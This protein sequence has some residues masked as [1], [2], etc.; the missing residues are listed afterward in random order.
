[1]QLS[2]FLLAVALLASA[3]YV[4]IYA[5]GLAAAPVRSDGFGYFVYL[6]AAVVDRDLTLETTARECCGGTFPD[7]AAIIRWPGTNRLVGAHP[8]GV[9]MLL[10]PLYVVAHLLTLWSNLPPTGWSFYYQHA[11]GLG[12]VA[13]LVAGLA[14]LGRTLAR[15][16]APSSVLWTLAVVTFGTNLFHYGTFD[17]VYSHVF[18]FLLV[19][20][21]IHQV[22]LWF[23]A[24]TRARA[25]GI[26][27]I[28]SLVVLVRHPNAVALALIPAYGLWT[29]RSLRQQAALLWSRRASLALMAAAAF[30]VAVP[31]M[32]MYYRA[33]GR[34]L[35]SS[36]GAMW[37]HFA[38]PQLYGVL[39]SVQKGVFFWAPLLLLGVGG[40]FL[41]GPATP[42]V[43]P[44]AIVVPVTVYLIASWW[45][46]QYGG[47]FGHRGFTDLAGLFALGIAAV[48]E[49]ARRHRK[50]ALALRAAAVVLMAL[51]VA[52]MLQ[53][54]VGA[55]P[56][57][58]LTWP[59][60]RDGFL[61]F[62]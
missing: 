6:P 44:I 50:A 14:V 29:E 16:V 5:A 54:W 38:D 36:Y 11:A 61:R 27:A 42:F 47:S 39:F 7:W 45:D 23:E 57:A 49:R 35:V 56:I 32:A 18:S 13:A 8:T 20:G 52:Q 51:S 40:W 37:F 58:D 4:W 19:C 28:A 60:Y 55:L 9:A 33:T 15:R 1:V 17:S 48:F 34:V 10:L 59:Q 24:P 31:Q 21:L 53:Y 46:W 30:A 12:G 2:R 25:M 43:A 41:R 22:P 3:A 26:G 62:R